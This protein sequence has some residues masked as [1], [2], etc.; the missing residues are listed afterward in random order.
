MPDKINLDSSGLRRSAC[1]A[2]LS[3]REKVYSHSTTVL[4][5][6]KRS[7]KHACLVLFSSFCA[8]GAALDGGVH[9]HQVLLQSSSLLSNAINSYHRVNSLY[10]GTINC[11]ST[12]AQ[13]T[14]ASNE[15]FNYKE[16]L[17]QP[18]K[19]EFIKAMINE[20]DDHETRKH[21]TLMKRCDLPNGTKTIMAIWSFKRKR[22]P[23]GTLNKHKARL[24]AHGGMQT[25]GQNY[26]ETYAPVVNWASVRILLAVAKIHGL[27]SK[28]IDFVLAFPQADLEVPVY[29]E[30]PLGFDT[31]D[32]ENLKFYILRLNKSLYGLKQAGYNWFAKLSNGLEDRGFVPS[33]V[34]PCVFFGK[35]CIVLTYVDDCIIVADSLIRIDELIKSLHGGD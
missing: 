33:S 30:L 8:I 15:T 34:D 10:D 5:S 11:F 28:S 12:M 31:P 16:A 32:N 18:D 29:M 26:W 1:S 20:V 21:W 17:Q 4:K 24:C 27:P 23:D 35:G 22:Y 9:S 7:S 6:V 14:V 2:V 25:W 13:S 3:W 19:I